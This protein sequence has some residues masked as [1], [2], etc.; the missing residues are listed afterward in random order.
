MYLKPK[1]IIMLQFRIMIKPIVI[2]NLITKII[3]SYTIELN[4]TC[5]SAA[6]VQFYFDLI[7]TF[8]W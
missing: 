3:K 1:N 2:I 7:S 8:H 5:F 6:I 4:K